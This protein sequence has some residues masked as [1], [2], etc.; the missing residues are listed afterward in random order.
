MLHGRAIIDLHNTRTHKDE[1]IVHDNMLTNWIRDSIKPWT[2]HR[3]GRPA[4]ET[5]GYD[6]IFGGLMMFQSALSNDADDYL[7]PSPHVNKMIA[8]GNNQTYSGTDL[9]RG[10]YN[11]SQSSGD[12]G[13]ITKVWDFTQEQGNGTI[14]SLGL[15]SI[16]FAICGNGTK[17]I[18]AKEARSTYP[19]IYVNRCGFTESDRSRGYRFFDG[20]NGTTIYAKV[21]SGVLTMVEVP[22]YWTKFLPLVSAHGQNPVFYIPSNVS[23]ETIAAWIPSKYSPEYFTRPM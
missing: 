23:S 22:A 5:L 13:S 2:I 10:S 11:E 7:F 15:C 12:D 14:A 4:V 3:L 21:I 6:D 1:R 17:G 20:V 16:R 9:T 8:H 18:P 19:R